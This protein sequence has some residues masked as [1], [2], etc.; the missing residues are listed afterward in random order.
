MSNADT[1]PVA[2]FPRIPPD[3]QS[4][5][6]GF[7]WDLMWRFVDGTPERINITWECLDRHWREAT[8]LRIAFDD[9]TC[10]T[11][12]FGTLSD[13]AA[14]WAGLLRARGIGRGDRVALILQPCLDFYAAL[15]GALKIGAVAVPLHALFGPEGIQAR[16]GY[17]APK[18]V[19]VDAATA[20]LGAVATDASVLRLNESGRALA[21]A[22][23]VT[24]VADT[25]AEDDALI[26]FTSGTT[27][28]MPQPIHHRH[29]AVVTGLLPAV[30]GYGITPGD[31]CFCV[32]PP[33]WGH[34]LSFGTIAPL[35]L[36]TAV[37]AW[38]GRFDPRR[39]AAALAEFGITNLS[40]APTVYRQLRNSGAL[41]GLD[42]AIR[43][44]SYTGEAMDT[45]T[46]SFLAAR[47]NTPPCGV[48]GTAEVSSF[49]ANYCGFS[50]FIVKPDALGKPLPGRD[51][52]VQ[53]QDGSPAPD[54]EMGEIVLSR[55]GSWTPSKDV[56]Y[57]DA[58]GYF[59][60]VGRGDDVIIS[61]GWTISPREIED[62][63]LQHP[64]VREAAVVASPDAVR[65]F[66]PKAFLVIEG[67]AVDGLAET[68][69]GFVKQQLSAAQYPRRVEFVDAIPKTPA[70]KIDRVALRR[71]EAASMGAQ[72]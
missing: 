67:E 14:R 7:S 32:S 16:M 22:A 5:A 26:Q 72:R 27:R 3:W 48:Y 58:D 38:S 23:P 51:V 46:F 20:H 8:A 39:L 57:R 56:G 21:A 36:G 40:A 45:D 29:R 55:K 25:A 53:R 24:E 60:I 61:A 4:A 2:R 37:G 11:C 12:S 1:S 52:R 63:L 10:F 41:D 13:R 50:G 54:G 70:G 15:F 33:S 19:L 71:R 49:L 64:F 17:A 34:G 59:H 68:L 62:V 31:R 69:Q 43:K 44:L 42:L 66:V 9:G 65:G 6:Q 18:L 35:A 30:Y 28:L 47:L